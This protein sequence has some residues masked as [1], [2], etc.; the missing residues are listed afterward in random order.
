MSMEV[1]VFACQQAVPEPDALKNLW[2]EAEVRLRVL[3]EPCSSKVEAFQ[4][5]RTLATPVDLVWVIGCEEQLCRY[6][7]GSHRAGGRMSYT[8]KYLAE[9]GLEPARVG[10]SVL[11]P[12]DVS[13]LAAIVAEIRD[14]IQALGAS[15]L[16]QA[17]KAAASRSAK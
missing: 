10:R 17:P 6:S 15:P 1:V 8:K 16:R 2:R 4:L 3:P 9:I 5:L 12:G 7:E 13:A 11:T 14:R